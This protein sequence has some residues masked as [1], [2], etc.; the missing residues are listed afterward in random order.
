MLASSERNKG[1]GDHRFPEST[2]ARAEPVLD[3]SRFPTLNELGVT[4]KQS[5]RW[6]QLAALSP[7]ERDAVIVEAKEKVAAALAKEKR[8]GSGKPKPTALEK[9]SK[10]WAGASEDDRAVFMAGEERQ[11]YVSPAGVSVPVIEAPS[12]DAGLWPSAP[13]EARAAFVRAVTPEA[14][15]E[16][17]GM[18][19]FY[20]AMSDGQ[21][22]AID[23]E[24]AESE[25]AWAEHER[26]KAREQLVRDIGGVSR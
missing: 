17:F 25:R 5:V 3:E 18:P 4:K 15:V 11:A 8:D 26:A 9:L 13:K 12:L 1:G 21:K 10:A 14:I 19:G 20:T 6:Q 2:G 22:D 7:E 16:A 24:I 23:D